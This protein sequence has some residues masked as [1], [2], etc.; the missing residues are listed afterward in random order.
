MLQKSVE[1]I[2]HQSMKGSVF[3]SAWGVY[4]AF[5]APDSGSEV[6]HGAFR[7]PLG[8]LSFLMLPGASPTSWGR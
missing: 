4:R 1:M 8:T 2:L 5:F 6:V 7:I 3:G